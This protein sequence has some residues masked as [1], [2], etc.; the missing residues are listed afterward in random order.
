MP[1]SLPT[2]EDFLARL[3]RVPEGSPPRGTLWNTTL[4]QLARV[5]EGLGEEERGAARD[6]LAAEVAAR[7]GVGV[8]EVVRGLEA[9]ADRLAEAAPSPDALLEQ[10][11]SLPRNEVPP[12]ERLQEILNGI[13]E[14]DEITRARLIQALARRTGLPRTD[15]RRWVEDAR[16]AM[17]ARTAAAEA[18]EAADER[19]GV[20]EQGR[21][22]VRAAFPD[23]P[24][25]D[26]LVLPRGYYADGAGT[27][28]REALG[29]GEP[30]SYPVSPCPIIIAR[31]MRD[32]DT[33]EIKVELAWR[34]TPEAGW[35]TVVTDRQTVQDS[36]LITKLAR[37]ADLVASS[38][39]ARELARYLTAFEQANY[40]RLPLVRSVSALGWRGGPPSGDPVYF[41]WGK[42]VIA[43]P[44]AAAPAVAVDPPGPGEAQ[45]LDAMRAGGSWEGWLDAF[46]I[47]FRHP[48]AA[49]AAYA[50]LASVLF[51]PLGL[52]GVILHLCNLT[53]RGKTT[54]AQLGAACWGFPGGVGLPG[55]A[56]LLLGWVATRVGREQ[57][58][59]FL[60][61]LPAY[62]DGLEAAVLDE[63]RAAKEVAEIAYM[64][65]DGVGK[66]RGAPRGSRHTA[67]WQLLAISTGEV[68]LHAACKRGGLQIRAVDIWAP[69]F[70]DASA[71]EQA[72]SLVGSH[73]GHAG[74]RFVQAVAGMPWAD[75]KARHAE[76]AERLR[77]A[78]GG[79]R[80]VDD[81]SGRYIA[82]FAAIALAAEVFHRECGK[83]TWLEEVGEDE[84]FGLVE[85]VLGDTLRHESPRH[86]HE[87]AYDYAIAWAEARRHLF[88]GG[89]PA[90]RAPA[91]GWLGTWSPD[92]RG[93][94]E[95]CIAFTPEALAQA[96]AEGG[97]HLKAVLPAWRDAKV[98]AEAGDP[99]HPFMR[100]VRM[101]EEGKR[102]WMY[103][104][105]R[106][107]DQDDEE[108]GTGEGEAEA[109]REDEEDLNF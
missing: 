62:F 4:A 41:V 43:A 35:Q 95:E 1:E 33:A 63:R 69:P 102:V 71:A 30:V 68:P 34:R 28:L 108:G 19:R 78:I 22:L 31:R 79:R 59:A 16:R 103:V 80:R 84:L 86:E 36:K 56:R 91:G 20:D 107:A 90:A 3:A 26:G 32:E 40:N 5:L 9:A 17:E 93:V 99:K 57:T 97:F 106:K 2:Q 24:A 92:L 61:H 81:L 11:E 44:G 46:R 7:F 47:A 21:V 82:P 105:K 60:R 45:L 100:Q 65:S 104:L 18:A 98:L 73:Y 50:S 39:I 67:T 42:E 72:R 51:A 6:R 76:L 37:E 94:A 83:G 48:V 109:A 96:L 55:S 101:G 66:L 77:A 27:I 8:E 14:Q 38:D 49:L 54:A 87:E 13:A 25:P 52:G 10:I 64:V 29:Q 15:V 58:C 75:L 74:P 12:A 23:A 89:D 85:C 70:A 53:C 88:W